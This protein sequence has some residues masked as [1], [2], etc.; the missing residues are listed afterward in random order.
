MGEVFVVDELIYFTFHFPIG[1][2]RVPAQL[3]RQ[4]ERQR[5][6]ERERERER[7]RDRERERKEE[8][9]E[10]ERERE[11][12]LQVLLMFNFDSTKSI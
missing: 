5:E 8:E 2:I 3:A 11:H 7:E 4:R 6:T 12:F 10:E 9:E 1:R